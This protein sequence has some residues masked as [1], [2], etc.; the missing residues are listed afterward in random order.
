MW[1]Q[2]SNEAKKMSQST[3][4]NHKRT[5]FFFSQLLPGVCGSLDGKKNLKRPSWICQSI[6]FTLAASTL[7]STSSFAGVGTGNSTCYKI[8]L[9]LQFSIDTQELSMGCCSLP[10]FTVR[11]WRHLLPYLESWNTATKGRV[12]Y[13]LHRLGHLSLFLFQQDF[14]FF[15]SFLFSELG[16]IWRWPLGHVR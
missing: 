13:C 12:L 1:N 14:F 5:Q 15:F 3:E 11:V 2:W 10:Q 16:G 4:T 9:H 6:A 7:I 8:S